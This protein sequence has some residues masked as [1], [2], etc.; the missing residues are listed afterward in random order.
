[1]GAIVATVVAGRDTY[2]QLFAAHIP[3]FYVRTKLEVATDNNGKQIDQL[4][5][6][7][8]NIGSE[9]CHA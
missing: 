4:V 3:E 9:N 8:A 5:V 7:I 2:I 1:M 6:R